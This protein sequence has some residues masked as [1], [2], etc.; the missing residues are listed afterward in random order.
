M[1]TR[2]ETQEQFVGWDEYG[3]PFT[4]RVRIGFPIPINPNDHFE[5]SDILEI[6]GRHVFRP[7]AATDGKWE[8]G[9]IQADT[10]SELVRLLT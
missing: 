7:S 9:W 5:D 3:E 4:S 6:N 8:C 1:L 10:L 2:Q